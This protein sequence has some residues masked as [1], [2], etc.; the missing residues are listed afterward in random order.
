MD[1]MQNKIQGKWQEIKGDI[2]KT[3]GNLTD[4][5]LDKTKGDMT[6]I[7]G[8][9]QQKYGDSQH[10]YSQKLKEIYERFIDKKD[11]VLQRTKDKLREDDDSSLDRDNALDEGDELG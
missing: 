8:L 4:D 11:D 3:W 6:S 5:E 1:S 7:G 2:K 10:K 9:I